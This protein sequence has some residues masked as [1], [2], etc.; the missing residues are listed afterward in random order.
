MMSFVIAMG[1]NVGLK[2][3]AIIASL[4]PTI[5]SNE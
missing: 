3:I 2:P 4:S 1:L 5:N